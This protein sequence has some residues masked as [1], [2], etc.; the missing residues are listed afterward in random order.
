MQSRV[1]QSER[2]RLVRTTLLAQACLSEAFNRALRM[3]VPPEAA[4]YRYVLHPVPLLD[5]RHGGSRGSLP[6]IGGYCPMCDETSLV[7]LQLIRGIAL[8]NP[9][10]GIMRR[11]G[12][13]WH[14]SSYSCDALIWPG[15]ESTAHVL[16][17]AGLNHDMKLAEGWATG[18]IVETQR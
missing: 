18:S 1:Y 7:Y 12:N 17:A 9:N 8:R 3:E 11:D 13:W 6:L 5:A 14:R 10:A 4:H 15:M 16:S 2:A